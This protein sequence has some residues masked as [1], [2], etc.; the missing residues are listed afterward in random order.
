MITPDIWPRKRLLPYQ[1]EIPLDRDSQIPCQKRAVGQHHI[2][3]SQIKIVGAPWE[4]VAIDVLGPLNMTDDE[5]KYLLVLQDYFMKWVEAFALP[6]QEA[7]TVAEVL[8]SNVFCHFGMPYELHSNQGSN[9][10][11]RLISELRKLFHI[12]K[13]R[14]TPYHHGVTG[15]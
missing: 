15:W 4:Q 3:P 12:V 8:T 10:E 5:N 1:I 11:S 7:S 14:T 13:T 2:A 6:D 9:F